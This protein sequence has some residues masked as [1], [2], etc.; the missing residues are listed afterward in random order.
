MKDL[1]KEKLDDHVVIFDGAVGTELYKRDFF[2]NASYENLCLEA[3]DAVSAIHRAY[4][5]AGA[6]VL[7][8]NSYNANRNKLQQYGLADKTAEINRAAVRLAKAEC[9][10]DNIVA[11]SIG[12]VGV[13][14]GPYKLGFTEKVDIIGE[15]LTA[16]QEAGA[17]FILCETLPSLEDTRIA[18]A[19]VEKYARI[20]FMFS[21]S[22]NRELETP[23]GEPLAK[24]LKVFSRSGKK[25]TAVG[26]NCNIGA[27]DMLEA[28]EQAVKICPFPLVV[29]PNAGMPKQIDNRMI[30]MC[31]PEYLTTYAIRFINLG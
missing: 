3:P 22:V 6:E 5:E 7:T 25:P 14:S 24:L 12:P 17:D 20:P 29:Q 10:A 16:L 27:N 26:L 1:L 4:V 9:A 21:F 30:Y 23:K 11:A 18:L 8:T 15:Q 2:V 28:L 19:A 13:E 31:S